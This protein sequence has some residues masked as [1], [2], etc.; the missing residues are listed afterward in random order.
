MDRFDAMR[1]FARLVEAG[2]FTKAAQTLHMSKTTVTQL[3]Q[4]LESRLRVRL[5]HRT[6]RKLGVTPDGAVYYERVIRLLADM[7]DAENSLSS[8]AMTPRG[9][10]RVDVPSPL[11]RLILVPALPAFHARYPDIQ[12]DMGVSDRVVDL[13]GDNVDCVLRGGQITDQSL[14]ARHV[15]D[16]QIGVYVAPSYVERLGA[17][18]HPRELQNTDHC[19]VGFL[20]SRTSKIDPLVLCSENERIEI[21][22]NYVLAVDDGNAYLEAGLVGLGVIALPNY[23]AAAHQAVGALIPLFTQWRISPMPLYLA[24]PPNRHVNAKLRVFIDWIV[25][26]MLQHVPIANNQ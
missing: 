3:I 15:G 23:M 17:P 2:S 4:Q 1:A 20:S 25:E 24:F 16:L 22:S 26:V 5:L 9:R 6:T 11:A 18:A 12:I 10:L 19:I 21:T 14:I 8:A 13:I 7:E